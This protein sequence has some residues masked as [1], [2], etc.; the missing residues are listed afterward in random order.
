MWIKERRRSESQGL[1]ARELIGARPAQHAP[2][3]ADDRIRDAESVHFINDAFFLFLSFFVA[4]R[5]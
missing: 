1:Q 5:I 2:L 3:P 4:Q